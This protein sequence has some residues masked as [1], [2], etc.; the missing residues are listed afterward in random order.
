M[1]V[2]WNSSLQ[3][4]VVQTVATGRF[5]RQTILTHESVYALELYVLDCL[6]F[7]I[8]LSLNLCW[9]MPWL[10]TPWEA[11]NG[12]DSF[13]RFFSQSWGKWKR[14]QDG[15]KRPFFWEREKEKE[16][17]QPAVSLSC[18]SWWTTNL[19]RTTGSKNWIRILLVIELHIS[20]IHIS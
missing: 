6:L 12:T 8:D 18:S 2:W 11:D 1:R 19:H 10:K 5:F 3:A 14:Q 13:C 9:S 16:V 15:N 4:A 20:F 17:S 7:Q